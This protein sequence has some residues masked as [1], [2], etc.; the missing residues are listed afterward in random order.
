MTF[1]QG[2]LIKMTATMKYQPEAAVAYAVL[3]WTQE[4]ILGNSIEL[5]LQQIW[6]KCRSAIRH[7]P[8]KYI[9]RYK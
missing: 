7:G 9:Q 3:L 1:T 6:S 4:P 2:H 8:W 5:D